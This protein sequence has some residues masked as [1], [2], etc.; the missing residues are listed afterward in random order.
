[1]RCLHVL[2]AL[3]DRAPVRALMHLLR[4]AALESAADLLPVAHD[5][6][7]PAGGALDETIRSCARRVIVAS[8]GLE[9]T[10][11]V[12][13]GDYDVVHALDRRIARRLA[14]LLTS[15]TSA[16]FVFSA[17]AMTHPSRGPAID[18]A[19]RAILA[20]CDLVVLPPAAAAIS[21]MTASIAHRSVH[22][23]LARLTEPAQTAADGGPA[24]LLDASE[25]RFIARE[26]SATLGAAHRRLSHAAREETLHP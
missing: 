17:P 15:A 12:L 5:V 22:L 19:E 3:D 11:A 4:L 23:E 21:A 10:A 2:D 6:L 20:A 26:W 1:M 16:A 8:S 25:L 9:L 24:F 7:T 13:T 18:T 14:P